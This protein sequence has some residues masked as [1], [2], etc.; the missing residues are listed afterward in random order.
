MPK[1]EKGFSKEEYRKFVETLPKKRMASGMIF[2]DEQKKILMV[3]PGYKS[4]LEIPGG[5]VEKDESPFEAC[6]REL[7]EELGLALKIQR[8][9]CVDYNPPDE[10]KSESLMFIFYG[11]DLN[12]ETI[13]QIKVDGKEIVNYKFLELE[14]IKGKTTDSLFKRI[15]KSVFAIENNASFYL[16]NQSF[17]DR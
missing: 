3:V 4:M 14:E 2:R 6:K 5:V 16:E 1:E 9:L 10:E 7:K 11:G 12:K 8:L 17:I 15:E 13:D